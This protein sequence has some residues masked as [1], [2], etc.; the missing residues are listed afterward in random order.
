MPVFQPG[1]VESA[2]LQGEEEKKKAGTWKYGG[3][4]LDSHAYSGGKKSGCLMPS[5]IFNPEGVGDR[6][7]R[8]S[9]GGKKKKSA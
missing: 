2:D 9:G 3:K 5:P 7:R 1:R 6:K 4:G 8:T